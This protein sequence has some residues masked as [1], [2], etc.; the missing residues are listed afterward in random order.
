MSGFDVR[1]SEG[2]HH[3]GRKRSRPQSPDP[4]GDVCGVD[5]VTDQSGCYLGAPRP[6]DGGEVGNDEA[7]PDT[8]LNV[9]GDTA[10]ELELSGVRAG[11]LSWHDEPHQCAPVE[12]SNPKECQRMEGLGVRWFPGEAQTSTACATGI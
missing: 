6:L 9:A 3:R 7:A 5:Y 8:I 11:G 2:D 4:F 10:D 1:A 12:P